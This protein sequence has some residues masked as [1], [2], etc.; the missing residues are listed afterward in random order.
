MQERKGF[1]Q[2]QLAAT[3]MNPRF[4][5]LSIKQNYPAAIASSQT[6]NLDFITA[7]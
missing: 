2:D 5:I 1:S 3:K 6:A 4:L 7:R